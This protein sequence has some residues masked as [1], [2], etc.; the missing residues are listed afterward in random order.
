MTNYVQFADMNYKMCTG[1]GGLLFS[2]RLLETM[3][4]I[5]LNPELNAVKI[6]F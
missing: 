6:I 1:F 3:L 4:T 5:L 2:R